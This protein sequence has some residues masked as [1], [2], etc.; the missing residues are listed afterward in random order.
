M[1]R[2]TVV[3]NLDRRPERLAGFR[4]SY[5]RSGWKEVFGEPER[6][7]AVDGAGLVGVPLAWTGRSPG[8]F[9]CYL[10]HLEVLTDAL[11]D[12]V[13][14]LVVFEDDAI[15]SE[16]SVPALQ[17]FLDR[18]PNHY[19]LWLGGHYLDP[20]EYARGYQRPIEMWCTHAYVLSRPAIYTLLPVLRASVGPVDVTMCEHLLDRMYCPP[21][22]LV[23]Q[24]GYPSDINQDSNVNW[25][26]RF[27]PHQVVTK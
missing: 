16:E 22:L 9:G 21:E 11:I 20:A 7:E 17:R 1:K 26:R 8:E 2:R 14:E 12:Q 15:F 24:G 10:S 6:V 23:G 3:I 27:H 19:A 25:W 18:A 5:A 4:E 13:D